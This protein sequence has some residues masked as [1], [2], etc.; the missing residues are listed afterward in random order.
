MACSLTARA[1][2]TLRF[3]RADKKEIFGRADVSGELEELN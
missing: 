2:D 1:A 3:L